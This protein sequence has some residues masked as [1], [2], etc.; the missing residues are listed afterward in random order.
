M[1]V[2]VKGKIV[3]E[4]L[5][6]EI[7]M[8][9]VLVA[10]RAG[11]VGKTTTTVMLADALRGME[12]LS[13]APAHVRSKVKVQEI[14]DLLRMVES[15][16]VQLV[17]VDV[18][19]GGNGVGSNLANRFPRVLPVAVAPSTEELAAD[20]SLAYSHFDNLGKALLDRPC[21]VD[22]GANVIDAFVKWAAL[23]GI[24]EDWAA[25][26][27]G[28]DFVAPTTA[29]DR[30]MTAA[31]DAVEAM[32]ELCLPYGVDLRCYIVLNQR[33]G[34]FE[35]YANSKHWQRL[36]ALSKKTQT[37][38]LHLKRCDGDLLAFVD[39][40]LLT[41]LAVTT[42]TDAEIQARLPHLPVFAARRSAQLLLGW[43]RE[44]LD[45]MIQEGL[46][47]GPVPR[48]AVHGDVE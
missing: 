31:A 23:A 7:K 3:S 5:G 48:I 25:G 21:L 39:Q 1:S 13:K 38:S 40:A 2:G 8:R 37:T 27:I 17:D 43:Y 20:P 32:Q 29:E 24:G 47:R 41:P 22:F 26:G 34:V 19:P 15:Q 44:F 42:M 18:Q 33:D 46:L 11:G 45:E 10:S 14:E 4:R 6:A 12:T 28:I 36:Q 9:Q 35:K 30:A 16:E